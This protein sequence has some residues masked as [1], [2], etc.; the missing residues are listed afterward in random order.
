MSSSDTY[1]SLIGG[2]PYVAML[3][4]ST[5]GSSKC[6]DTAKVQEATRLAKELAPY[7][8]VNSVAPGWVDTDMNKDLDK[9]FI[10]K[11]RNKI[12]LNRFAKPSEIAK[13][14]YFLT[15]EAASYINGTIIRVDGGVK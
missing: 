10:E 13:V 5:Y 7:I 11:E 1:E 6:D 3:S 4:H 8:R 12:L 2:T 9:E 15:T 14:I